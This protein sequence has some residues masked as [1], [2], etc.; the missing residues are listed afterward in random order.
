[1]NTQAMTPARDARL[2]ELRDLI[3]RYWDLAYAKG[4]EGRDHDTENGDAQ[5]C[6]Y[7]IEKR[8]HAFAAARRLGQGGGEVRIPSAAEWC[9]EN[10][11]EATMEWRAGWDACRVEYPRTAP[12]SAPVGVE[13]VP[14]FNMDDMALCEAGVWSLQESDSH[15]QECQ[16]V[17]ISKLIQFVYAALAQHPA[18]VDGAGKALAEQVGSVAAFLVGYG[19]TAEFAAAKLRDALREYDAA[20]PG[21]SDNDC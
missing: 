3:E 9:D 1:M 14:G 16:A 13:A 10:A 21:G 20:Q 6:L 11:A 7:Q 12:P 15:V 2:S 5:E 18:A 19:D 4:K 17:A 8:L